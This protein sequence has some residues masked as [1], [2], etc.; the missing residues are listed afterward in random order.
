M[1]CRQIGTSYHHWGFFS[2]QARPKCFHF[3]LFNFIL[4]P[5]IDNLPFF[6]FFARLCI[7]WS[8]FFIFNAERSRGRQRI[9]EIHV[10]PWLRLSVLAPGEVICSLHSFC[11]Y[12]RCCSKSWKQVVP[13]SCS[14][15]HFLF[16]LC[17]SSRWTLGLS[18]FC[19]IT[20]IHPWWFVFLSVI[21]KR[22]IV[23]LGLYLTNQPFFLLSMVVVD[24]LPISFFAP[25]SH[26]TLMIFL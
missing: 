8:I 16:Q 13:G 9:V 2:G 7:V 12:F 10:S 3:L 4:L 25:I 15:F 5:V 22:S 17:I 19:Q 11:F 21:D 20:D 1:N 23:Y 6:T 26:W 24:G 18:I 14:G